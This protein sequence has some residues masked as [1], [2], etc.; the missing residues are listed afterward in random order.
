MATSPHPQSQCHPQFRFGWR[1]ARHLVTAVLGAVCGTVALAV[2]VSGQ[3]TWEATLQSRDFNGDGVVDAYYDTAHD[4][5]WLADNAAAAG[6]PFDDGFNSGDGRL[7]FASALAWTASLEVHGVTG[8]RLP[9]FLGEGYG[10]SEVSRMYLTT[11]A[12]SPF[13]DPG[14]PPDWLNTGPFGNLDE[15]QWLSNTEGEFEAWVWAADGT[16]AYHT[17]E[18]LTTSNRAWAVRSGDVAPIPE[19]ETWALMLA[20]LGAVVVAARRGRAPG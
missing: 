17:A 12:N 3:G 4:L 6:G 14:N 5:T 13:P 9:A 16:G 8:W 7:T 11:L 18:P 2:P 10:T 20:G 15:W 19:P 1:P